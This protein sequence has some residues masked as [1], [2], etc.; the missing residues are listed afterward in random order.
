LWQRAFGSD[1]S[2]IGT[3]IKTAFASFPF[4]TSYFGGPEQM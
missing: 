4:D 3:K 1:R 2:V